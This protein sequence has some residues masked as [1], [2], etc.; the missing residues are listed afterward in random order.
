MEIPGS[1]KKKKKGGQ[2]NTRNASEVMT[3]MKSQH[4]QRPTEIHQKK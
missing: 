1:K 2:Q 4:L 3:G